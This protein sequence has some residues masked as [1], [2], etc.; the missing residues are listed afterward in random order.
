MISPY[1]SF[2]GDCEAAF[3]FYER[4]LGAEI[5]PLFRYEGS[6]LA[7]GVPANWSDKIMH[8][9]VTVDG[10]VLMGADIVPDKYEAPRGF[11]LSIQIQSIS[12]AERIYSELATGGRVEMPLQE[13]FWAAR[14]GMLVDQFGI[15]WQ[16][17]CEEPG[18]GKGN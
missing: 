8:G 17:N 3:R 9:S 14:F 11:T 2:K 12:D 10:Q 6:P 1:L 5:G 7:D 4:C 18:Q 15:P 16:I 13:T